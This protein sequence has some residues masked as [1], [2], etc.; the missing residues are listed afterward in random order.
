MINLDNVNLIMDIDN[1]RVFLAEV[2]KKLD[3]IKD[4]KKVLE[5]R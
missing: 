5:E 4:T 2:N 1:K 3:I